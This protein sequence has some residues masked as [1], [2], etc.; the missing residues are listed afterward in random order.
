MAEPKSLNMNIVV[1]IK[2]VPDTAEI[3]MDPVTNTL[4]RSGVPSAINP[5]DKY[6][7][8]A[9]VRL[10]E[11]FGG[12]VTAI[13]MGPEQ[14]VQALKECYALG[15]DSMVIAS[16]RLFGGADTFATSYVLAE[17]I[18]KLGDYDLIIC[19]RQA[20]D[21]DTAQVGPM[22]AEHLGIP[23]MTCASEITVDGGTVRIK[24]ERESAYAVL[25]AK[26]PALIT[27]TKSI[28]EPRLPNIMRRLKADKI[29]PEKIDAD[30]LPELDRRYI[31][32][33]GSPTKV[34]KIYIPDRT[35]HTVMIEG[36][37]ADEIASSLL[38]KLEQAKVS[39]AG[40]G[41]NE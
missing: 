7:L 32:L 40:G 4:Q 41:T 33:S 29:S 11:Q 21:G 30:S 39:L 1:C 17:A 27:V 16:D 22:I 15:A 36:T 38:D 6:A 2:Q 23:Q 10:R 24:Q 25:E 34:R 18:K 9:A 8:E 19:G 3:K 35:K 31:G 37:S 14:A 20:I 5:F 28:N 13:T 26:L 12:K